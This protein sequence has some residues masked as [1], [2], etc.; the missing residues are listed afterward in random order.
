[1]LVMQWTAL[2]LAAAVAISGQHRALLCVLLITGYGLALL[3]AQ[4]GLLA[5]IPV[6]LLLLASVAVRT[7][8]YRI[9]QVTG[10][11]LLI[12]T[13]CALALHLFPG[14]YNLNIW[15]KV[16]ITP[17]AVPFTMY[18][19]LDKP[20]IAFWLLFL[21]PWIRPTRPLHVALARGAQGALAVTVVCLLPAMALGLIV[22]SPKL[23]EGSW[24]WLLNNLL[25]ICF[26]EEVLF[27]GYLQQGI[28]RRLASVR[29]HTTLAI[30]ITASLFGLAHIT[31]GWHMVLIAGI[32]GVGYGIAFRYGGLLAAILAHCGFNTVHFFL[33]T[34]PMLSERASVY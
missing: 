10:H 11:A 33:F 34:Y 4:L 2:F 28:S 27:R 32:A 1:M 17:D 13:A 31:G 22:W 21:L 3:N 26:A 24:L 7:K 6:A 30:V 18:L 29:Y 9:Y 19:N 16:Q 23:P 14:F 5:C 25:L 15:D 20:L 8:T 12:A